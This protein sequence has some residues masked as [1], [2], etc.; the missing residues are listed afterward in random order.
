[1]EFGISKNILH[2]LPYES[3]SVMVSKETT[4]TTPVN[5]RTILP[6]GTILAGVD[7]SV[8]DDETHKRLAVKAT[9]EAVPDGITLN[10]VDVTEKDATVAMV[11]RGTVYADKII[12]YADTVK[13]QLPD[14]K[15]VK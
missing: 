1:M 9:G 4:G 11:F 13:A 10:D 15:F 12:D 14:I 3:I 7:G 8:F 5:G 2:N 6:A